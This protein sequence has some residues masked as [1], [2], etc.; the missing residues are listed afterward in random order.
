MEAIQSSTK[1]QNT[2]DR[3]KEEVHDTKQSPETSPTKINEKKSEVSEKSVISVNQNL[4]E[5]TLI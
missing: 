1:H 5:L 2:G 4:R 3:A